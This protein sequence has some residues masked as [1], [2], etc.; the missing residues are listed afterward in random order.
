M[1]RYQSNKSLIENHFIHNNL[2]KSNSSKMERKL[3]FTISNELVSNFLGQIIR[4]KAYY[5]D[6]YLIDSKI[7][8]I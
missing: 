8:C 1:C 3:A 2:K 4:I 6:R 7:T 5:K